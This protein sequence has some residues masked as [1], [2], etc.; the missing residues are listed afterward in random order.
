MPQPNADLK[1]LGPNFRA[2]LE[3]VREHCS[4]HLASVEEIIGGDDLSD[5]RT[6]A[7]QL[8]IAIGFSAGRHYQ[9]QHPELRHVHDYPPGTFGH[10]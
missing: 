3:Y 7:F 6:Q 2:V 5:H 10:G 9:L 8:L 4:Q 1:R